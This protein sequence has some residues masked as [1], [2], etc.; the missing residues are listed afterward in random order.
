MCFGERAEAFRFFYDLVPEF[1]AFC[2]REV[3]RAIQ[4]ALVRENAIDAAEVDVH[5]AFVVFSEF[6]IENL[7]KPACDA[8]DEKLEHVITPCLVLRSG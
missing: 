7:A 5:C 6:V 8:H 3:R 2:Q 4:R 1:E